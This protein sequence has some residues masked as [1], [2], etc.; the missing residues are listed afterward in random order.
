MASMYKGNI[1]QGVFER[2][3]ELEAKPSTILTS[4]PHPSVIFPVAHERK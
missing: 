1:I 2:L 4:R 3:V